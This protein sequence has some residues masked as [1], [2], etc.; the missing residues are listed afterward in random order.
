MLR[1]KFAGIRLVCDF[2]VAF[3]VYKIYYVGA[4][5]GVLI[6]GLDFWFIRVVFGAFF[7][8]G[9]YWYAGKLKD[10]IFFMLKSGTI[11]SECCKEDCGVLEALKCVT[12]D[13][14]ET[15]SIPLIN[16]AVRS[17]FKQ[18]ANKIGDETPEV[19]KPLES[20]SIYQTSKKL[21][22]YTFDYA[23]ECT[24]AWCYKNEDT[25]LSE[26]IT[27]I[28]LFIKH[29]GE[30]MIYI[31]PVILLQTIVRIACAIGL[32]IAY[33]HFMPISIVTLVGLIIFLKAS[34]F[35][36]SDALLEPFCMDGVI[37]KFIA[38]VEKDDDA[39]QMQESLQSVLDFG[40]LQAILRRFTDNGKDG[41]DPAVVGDTEEQELD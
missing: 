27:G 21:A 31:A 1:W 30:L 25:L 2:I 37:R 4:D 16:R 12:C 35:I 34:D 39:T 5:L 32:G 41:A 3:F 7:A 36:I 13:W 17:V 19:L 40:D 38:C 29:A 14:K 18:V 33:L 15:F 10:S 6:T 11:W 24:L 9:V 28:C 8:A 26:C 20:S 23:D 22:K